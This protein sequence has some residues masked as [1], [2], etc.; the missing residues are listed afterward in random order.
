MPVLPVPDA[1]GLEV[2]PE[3]PELRGLPF[4]V[5]LHVAPL[6]EL[7][8]VYAQVVVVVHEL[9]VAEPPVT[10]LLHLERPRQDL[11]HDVAVVRIGHVHIE[12]VEN[13]M[14]RSFLL[15]NV[16]LDVVAVFAYGDVVLPLQ[17]GVPRVPYPPPQ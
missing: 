10:E 14:K 3:L 12:A 5:L 16:G 9:P 13:V 1:L 7:P 17:V 4:G 8:L 15:P 2:F 6:A 11:V